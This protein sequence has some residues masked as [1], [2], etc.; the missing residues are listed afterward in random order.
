[1]NNVFNDAQKIMTINMNN[2]SYMVYSFPN[3]DSYSVY[4]SK[5][6]KFNPDH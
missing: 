4:T 3:F 5:I 6:I 1:M 2:A